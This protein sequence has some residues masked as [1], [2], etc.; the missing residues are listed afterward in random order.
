MKKAILF[1][2]AA[3]I[4]AASFSQKKDTTVTPKDTTIQLLINLNQYRALLYKIDLNIDSKK[5]SK[6]LLDFLQK[7][8]SIYQPAEKPKEQTKPKQ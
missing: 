7:S 1:A 8:A 2:I 5:E 3:I 6:E 4:S